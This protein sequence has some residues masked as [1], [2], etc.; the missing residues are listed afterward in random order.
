MESSTKFTE[1]ILKNYDQTKLDNVN[2]Q[3]K[4][5]KIIQND[6]DYHSILEFYDDNNN[7]LYSKNVYIVGIFNHEKK[8]WISGWYLFN[9]KDSLVSYDTLRYMYPYIYKE[10]NSPY[11]NFKKIFL[12]SYIQNMNLLT[13][14]TILAFYSY[15]LKYPETIIFSSTSHNIEIVHNSNSINFNN[16]NITFYCILYESNQETN[17]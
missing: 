5:I 11:K 16:N 3:T 17:R 2:K 13:C 1:N 12:T 9:K 6:S 7:K 14:E 10:K 4:N 8:I 15:F